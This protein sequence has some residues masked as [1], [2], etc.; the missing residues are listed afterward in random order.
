MRIFKRMRLL[1]KYRV[2][3]SKQPDKEGKYVLFH[4]M[5]SLRGYNYQRVFKGSFKECHTEKRRLEKL[6]LKD[7]YR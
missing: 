6:K 7:V 1:D 3:P 4:E 5:K 2:E